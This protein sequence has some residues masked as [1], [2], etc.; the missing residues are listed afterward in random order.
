M[1]S[2]G[3]E[4]QATIAKRLFFK[5][6]SLVRDVIPDRPIEF[7]SF[8]DILLNNLD[9]RY[10]VDIIGK[11]HAKGPIEKTSKDK[12]TM[13]IE[14]IDCEDQK[15]ILTLWEKLA[16]QMASSTAEFDKSEHRP[17]VIIRYAKKDRIIG[18]KS[19][20]SSSTNLTS[21]RESVANELLDLPARRTIDEIRE[22]QEAGYFVTL[23]TIIAVDTKFKW[24]IESCKKCK[25]T[26][27][28]EDKDKWLCTGK[29]EGYAKFV[30]LMHK[31]RVKV[32]DH[33]G[34]ATFILFDTQATDLIKQ[35]AKQ[36]RDNQLKDG[37]QNAHPSELDVLLN[38][39]FIFKVKV[40][41]KYNLT[42]CWKLY[43]VNKL[44]EDKDLI[45]KYLETCTTSQKDCL[46]VNS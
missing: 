21:Y 45:L 34:N 42:K 36:L 12:R 29:C 14:L 13:L 10:L 41:E 32:A 19:S 17:I 8:N 37:D 33:T 39:R 3:T 30:I 40:D 7:A 46:E 6:K 35:S 16:D 18:L 44:F 11:L 43:G 23:A 38:R 31:V 22:I 1:D 25:S 4:I 9:A 24:Y 2:E 28:L 5:Y 20:S 15:L 27:E 26:M